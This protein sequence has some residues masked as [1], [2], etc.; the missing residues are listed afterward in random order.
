[1]AKTGRSVH[2]P[3]SALLLERRGS[4]ESYSVDIVL[5]IT[6]DGA[7]ILP[8]LGSGVGIASPAPD[9]LKKNSDLATALRADGLETLLFGDRC[10]HNVSREMPAAGCERRASA[11]LSIL[12]ASLPS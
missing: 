7:P 4:R 9:F 12:E 10:L 1:M 8:R 11:A 5:I 6:R 2:G 3:L